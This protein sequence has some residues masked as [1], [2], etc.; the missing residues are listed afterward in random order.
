M[1][2]RRILVRSLTMITIVF[3]L[4]TVLVGSV[5]HPAFYSLCAGESL[6]LWKSDRGMKLLIQPH[7]M[8]RIWMAGA[9]SP[10]SYM[11]SSHAQW[12]LY[13]ITACR[14]H[15]K[16]YWFPYKQLQTRVPYFTTC[17]TLQRSCVGTKRKPLL[18]IGAAWFVSGNTWHLCVF[19]TY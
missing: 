5:A 4:Q 16:I 17:S 10:F 11:T 6:S 9:V 2:V 8:R 1:D 3:L 12:Q 13:L 15:Y 19:I 7:I 14:R 18:L